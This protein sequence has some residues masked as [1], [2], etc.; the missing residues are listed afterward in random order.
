KHAFVE[1]HQMVVWRFHDHWHARRPDGI[2]TGM[3][4]ILGWE[5]YREADNTRVLS[6]PPTSL[7]SLA[8][9]IQKHRKARTM[10]IVGDPQLPV[11]K[12]ALNPGYAS[13]QGAARALAR[14]QVDVLVVGESREWEGVE[15]AQ[16]AIAAGM[17]KGLIILG[18][19]IS[20]ENG[21]NEC[22]R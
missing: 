19:V 3:L 2:F 5:K 22:A 15:Y 10:R 11:S 21:M 1:S 8:R 13:L 20:E 18:H 14:P 7:S 9:D 17:K 12:V 16:D 6:L 4:E